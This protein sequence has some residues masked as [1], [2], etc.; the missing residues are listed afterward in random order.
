MCKLNFMLF[1]TGIYH[2]HFS[3]VGSV[4]MYNLCGLWVKPLLG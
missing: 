4:S 2:T 1:I 3:A